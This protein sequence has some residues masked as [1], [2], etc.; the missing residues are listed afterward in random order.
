M[1]K[2]VI[3]DPSTNWNTYAGVARLVA[4]VFLF[5]AVVA[6][7]T[8]YLDGTMNGLLPDPFRAAAG[9]ATPPPVTLARGAGAAAVT[10]VA[11]PAAA[12]EEIN[13][14]EYYCTPHPC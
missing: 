11:K 13:R 7:I 5:A 8:N 10:A 6:G 1:K 14:E 2:S 12:E 3:S 4:G 9:A